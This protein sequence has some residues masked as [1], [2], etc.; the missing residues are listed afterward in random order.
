MAT[1]FLN[2]GIQAFHK[3]QTEVPSQ[4]PDGDRAPDKMGCRVVLH[5]ICY[6]TAHNLKIVIKDKMYN[7]FCTQIPF[8]QPLQCAEQG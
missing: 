2:F 5:I 3:R 1:T 4:I 8:E 7:L 6:R